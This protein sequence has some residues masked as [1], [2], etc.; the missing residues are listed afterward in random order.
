MLQICEPHFWTLCSGTYMGSLRLEVVAQSDATRVVAM[1]RSIL[2]QVGVSQVT[3]EVT[4][5]D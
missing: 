4:P 3:I 2:K 5:V 1:A